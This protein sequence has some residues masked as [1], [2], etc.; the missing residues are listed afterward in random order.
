MKY[1][2]F[3]KSAHEDQPRLGARVGDIVIDLQKLHEWKGQKRSRQLEPLPDSMFELIYAGDQVW[4]HTRE[5]VTSIEVGGL[6][7]I[8]I[9]AGGKLAYTME[10]VKIYPPLLRPMTLRD[11]YAFEAHVKSANAIRGRE[12][13]EEWYRFPV[14]Y[15]SNPN[16][17]FGPGDLI[18]YPSYTKALDYELEV[19]CIIGKP[20]IN[21]RP[22]HAEDYIFGFTIFNDWSARDVQRM[23][24]KA[25]LGPA[26]GKDFAS[27]LGPYIVTQDELHDKSTGRPGVYDLTMTARVNGEQRSTGN[28]NSLHY[29]FGDMIARA[30]QDVYLLPG[31]VIGSGTVGTGCLLELTRAEGPWLK[32]GDQVELEVERLGVLKNTVAQL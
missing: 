4:D 29:S 18:P 5:L 6:Q 3:S 2:T 19:A 8:E 10:Q 25:G 31:E 13:P 22:E 11:F 7:E 9:E 17:I 21:I 15:F 20:G 26:K 14:F 30:S 16:T 23:E 27:S 12:V 28:W 1:L 32:P 24:M